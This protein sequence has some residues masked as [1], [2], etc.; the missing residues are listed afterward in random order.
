M[1]IPEKPYGVKESRTRSIQEMLAHLKIYF[2]KKFHKRGGSPFYETFSQKNFFL[3]DGFPYCMDLCISRL[4]IP[5]IVPCGHSLSLSQPFGSVAYY[6]YI[7]PAQL[8]S[9]TN[10][11]AYWYKYC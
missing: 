4:K 7:A 6:Y 1:A 5:R 10:T 9:S 2:A 11:V 3:K 8:T